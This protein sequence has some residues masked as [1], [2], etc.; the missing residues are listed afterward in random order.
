MR[1][2]TMKTYILIAIVSV[3]AISACDVPASKDNDTPAG[4]DNNI[5]AGKDNNIPAGKDNKSTAL[6]CGVASTYPKG[7]DPDP[8]KTLCIPASVTEIAENKYKDKPYTTLLFEPNSTLKTIGKAAFYNP[9]F[10]SVVIPDSV[11]TIGPGAFGRNTVG[12]P[13]IE[14]VVLGS[15][16][17]TIESQA[18]LGQS[19]ISRIII[20][21]SVQSI[22]FSAFTVG[23]LELLVIEGTP[24]L[25]HDATS[26]VGK[27][28]NIVGVGGVSI[29]TVRLT[30]A[31]YDK[32]NDTDRPKKFGTVT[33]YEDFEGNSPPT[34]N[35]LP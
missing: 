23:K 6:K 10:T 12:N 20:P 33:R 9:Q 18:F 28:F 7:V 4:K 29:E 32:Y 21:K 31:M 11:E 14:S 27:T 13:M 34:S 1:I 19:K 30:K 3:M 5:P 16:L 26:I 24:D 2:I 15:G 25:E 35:K 17:K 8:A 22:G